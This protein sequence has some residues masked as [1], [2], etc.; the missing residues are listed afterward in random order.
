MRSRGNHYTELAQNYTRAIAEK[1]TE[2]GLV[3]ILK[4]IQDKGFFN[5]RD[6]AYFRSEI[7]FRRR[8]ISYQPSN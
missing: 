5:A 4:E 3:K 6:E 1:T 7:E 8:E 2:D